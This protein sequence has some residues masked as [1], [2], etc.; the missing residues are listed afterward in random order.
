MPN[1]MYAMLAQ[2][3]K[4]IPKEGYN[5]IGLDDYEKA[6]DQLFVID[7]FKSKAEAE[8]AEKKYKAKHRNTKTF[9]YGPEHAGESVSEAMQRLLTPE[10]S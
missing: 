2:K 7:H 6:G 3:K 8:G 9:I 10:E 5:L 1:D 4:M